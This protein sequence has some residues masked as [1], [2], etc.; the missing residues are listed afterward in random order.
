MIYPIEDYD[1]LSNLFYKPIPIPDPT[2]LRSSLTITG[3]I[4]DLS[5]S[6]Y[7]EN[8]KV[9]AYNYSVYDPE[10]D[11]AG[12]PKIEVIGSAICKKDGSYYMV[13]EEDELIGLGIPFE[14]ELFVFQGDRQLNLDKQEIVIRESETQ[15]TILRHLKVFTLA[16]VKGIVR[17]KNF[18]GA[19]GCLVEL[20]DGLSEEV[21]GYAVTDLKGKYEIPYGEPIIKGLKKRSKLRLRYFNNEDL[22]KI[23]ETEASITDSKS[24]TFEMPTSKT[25]I[26]TEQPYLGDIDIDEEYDCAYEVSSIENTGDSWTVTKKIFSINEDES[27]EENNYWK[28]LIGSDNN[29]F[30]VLNRKVVYSA[31]KKSKTTYIR[32]T[33]D[34]EIQNISTDVIVYK[35]VI[36]NYAISNSPIVYTGRR[37]ETINFQF[38]KDTL[39]IYTRLTTRE[40]ELLPL[41]KTIAIEEELIPIRSRKRSY[42]MEEHPYVASVTGA[43]LKNVQHLGNARDLNNTLR[44]EHEDIFFGLIMKGCKADISSLFSMSNYALTNK[45]RKA[46]SENIIPEQ[47]MLIVKIEQL[48]D[49]IVQ[50]IAG[51]F[52]D[53]FSNISDTTILA[54]SNDE[55]KRSEFTKCLVEY[56]YD[57]QNIDSGFWEKLN[58]SAEDELKLKLVVDY[59][60]LCESNNAFINLFVESGNLVPLNEL[61]KL[62]KDEIIAKISSASETVQSEILSTNYL[63]EDLLDVNAFSALINEKIE[64]YHPTRSLFL[65]LDKMSDL[66]SS[67]SLLNTKFNVLRKKLIS[68]TETSTTHFFDIG[69][70]NSKEFNIEKSLVR[71]YTENNL[72]LFESF[73]TD[74]TSYTKTDWIDFM[75]LIQRV[76]SVTKYSI[77]ETLVYLIEKGFNSAFDVVK[78]G[79]TNFIAKTSD[80]LES[81]NQAYI[82]NAAE[83]KVNKALSLLNK[84]SHATNSGNPTVVSPNNPIAQS[85]TQNV[86]LLTLPDLEVLFGD[87]DITDT[88]H[89]ES[90]L[91]PAAYLVDILNLL[92]QYKITDTTTLYDEIIERRPD[93]GNIPLNCENAI[94]P[95]PYIDLVIEIL[96]SEI[97]KNENLAATNPEELDKFNFNTTKSSDQLKVNPENCLYSVYDKIEES[98][99]S[100]WQ[101]TPFQLKSEELKIY[102]EALGINRSKLVEPFYK[103]T[104]DNANPY[105]DALGLTKQDLEFVYPETIPALPENFL[106]FINNDILDPDESAGFLQIR[107]MITDFLDKSVMNLEYF[108]LLL[109]S[110]YVNP[111]VNNDGQNVRHTIHFKTKMELKNAYL[112]FITRD[113]GNEFMK[114]MYQFKRLLEITKWPV[115]VLDAV[116]LSDSRFSAFYDGGTANTNPLLDKTCIEEIGKA[117]KTQLSLNVSS[118]QIAGLYGDLKFLEYKNEKSFAVEYFEENN[119]PEEHKDSLK[120]LC[121]EGV[122]F[123]YILG[124]PALNTDDTFSSFIEYLQGVMQFDFEEMN[125]LLFVSEKS[126]EQHIITLKG[127]LNIIR[128]WQLINSINVSVN[129][130]VSICKLLNIS[131]NDTISD[132]IPAITNAY[133]L[134]IS[135]NVDIDELLYLLTHERLEDSKLPTDEDLAIICTNINAKKTELQPTL[136]DVINPETFKAY[137]IQELAKISGASNEI[138]EYLVTIHILNSKTLV[139]VALDETLDTNTTVKYIK[140]L[141]I[142]RILDLSQSDFENMSSI[143]LDIFNLPTSIG[144]QSSFNDFEKLIAICDVGIFLKPEVNR[145]EFYNTVSTNDK[146]AVDLLLD[147]YIQWKAI[148]SVWEHNEMLDP[149]VA[150][151]Y[152]SNLTWFN[153]LGEVNAYFEKK[154]IDTSQAVNWLKWNNIQLDEIQYISECAEKKLGTEVYQ[155]K[156][157]EGR[158]ELRIKQRN[159]LVQYILETELAK[160][161]DDRL[162]KDINDLY[163]YFLIDTQMTPAVSSS[164]IL[165]A[166]LAVQL[167]IQRIQF[168]LEPGKSLSQEDEKKWDWMGIYRVWEANRKI[169]LYPENWIEPELRDNKSTFFKELEKELTSSEL[170]KEVIENSY[171]NYVSKLE[172]V[173]NI[174]FCQMY[175]EEIGSYSILHVIGRSRFEPREYFY[176]K[177]INESYWT[178]W[179]K[180]NI[181]IHSE[182]IA[183]VVINDRLIVFWL[184]FFDDAK[185]PSDSDLKADTSQTT[186]QAKK[187]SKQLKVQIS[188]SEFIDKKWTEKRSCEQQV[189]YNTDSK[190]KMNYRFVYENGKNDDPNYLHIIAPKSA[191]KTGDSFMVECFNHILLTKQS[192]YKGSDYNIPDSMQPFAQKVK[193]KAQEDWV[194]MPVV[195]S[196]GGAYSHDI[197]ENIGNV[198]T[199]LYPHQYKSFMC[200]SPFVVE[201]KKQSVVFI[202]TVKADKISPLLKKVTKVSKT[203]DKADFIKD[204]RISDSATKF[205]VDTYDVKESSKIENYREEANTKDRSFN[206][207]ET[208]EKESFFTD[209]DKDTLVVKE[210]LDDKPV[211]YEKE[212]FTYVIPENVKFKPVINA[213]LGYHPYMGTMRNVLQTHGITGVLDPIKPSSNDYN[214]LLPKQANKRY[215]TDF[216]LNTEVVINSAISADENIGYIAEQFEFQSKGASSIY[217]WE[218]FFHIPYIISNRYF[219]E[220]N[221]DE[222]LKWLH[223]I[224]D[225]RVSEG[226]EPAKYWKFKPF[227]DYHATEGI[228]DLLYDLSMNEDSDSDENELNDQIEIWSSD[229][230]KPHNIAQIRISAYMKAVI[231]KYIDTLIARGDNSFRVDTMESINEATQY[232]ILGAQLLGKKPEILETSII[233]AKTYNEFESDAMGNGIEYFEEALIKPE[234]SAYLEKFVE[235]N[236]MEIA[237]KP[238]SQDKDLKDMVT[239]IFSSIDKTDTVAKQYFGIPKNDKMFGY[240][241]LVADRLFKIRN[242]LNI[243][244]YKRTVALFA[245]PIDPGML[246]KAAAAG[247]NI[248]QLVN[249]GDASLTQYRFQTLLQRAL[250]I[251]GEVK[252]LGAGLLS[253]LEKRDNETISK[254]RAGHELKLTE[255]LSSIKEKNIEDAVLGI[256]QLQ[257]QKEIINFRKAHYK[258]LEKISKKEQQQM[259]YQDKALKTQMH[260]QLLQLQASGLSLIPNFNVGAAGFGGT[261]HFVMSIGGSQL[262][263]MGGMIASAKGMES[264]IKSHKASRAGTM[265][266]YDRRKEDWDFQADMAEKELGQLEIQVLSAQIRKE[267]SNLDMKNHLSQIE[268]SKE[269]LEILSSKFTNEDLYLW[270]IGE[271]NTV[272][273]SAF[274]MAYKMAKQAE[275][276]YSFEL[277]PENPKSIITND[278]FDANNKGLLAGEKLYLQL[279]QMELDYLT[280]HKR[281]YELTKHVS[282]ALLD[283]QK[284]LDLR[285]G[286]TCEITLP[287]ILFNMDHPGHCNRRIK[288]VSLTIPC[289]SGAYTTISANLSLISSQIKVSATKTISIDSK[290]GTM[291]TSSSLNDSGMFELNF[292]DARYLPFEGAGVD[293]N[294]SLTLPN[295]VRQ[296]D[297]NSISDVILHINYTAQDGLSREVVETEVFNTLNSLASDS[298]MVSMFSLKSQYPE[299]WAE[300]G[301]KD[302]VIEIKKSQLPYYLQ[303]REIDV[304]GLIAY[305]VVGNT[306]IP[307]EILDVTTND[308]VSQTVTINMEDVTDKPKDIVL[309]MK[310]ITKDTWVAE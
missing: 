83:Y 171:L 306:N 286:G 25:E 296:F 108:K 11:Q 102:C 144:N 199:V 121:N 17:R 298:E 289:V 310:Y 9:C 43:S 10:S 163:S 278:H 183:P 135:H 184:E 237:A 261:P 14:L 231:M 12:E 177:L 15:T 207:E 172:K 60:E 201:S 80:V 160:A 77:F 245:P 260:S 229:P 23:S 86:Q 185:E 273:R 39:D 26:I 18:I 115:S 239:S 225:P 61:L 299:A 294:W 253:A 233:N 142:S 24:T 16:S 63:S 107:L 295:K 34:S 250:E 247:I 48:K 128:S 252:S 125:E 155:G 3:K 40:I 31:D 267:I 159:A 215:L 95:I 37:K 218:L 254:L 73:F 182:H 123:N 303:G 56:S 152:N 168:N 64:L 72:S 47:A 96:E 154:D 192:I 263:T 164:R 211:F 50:F 256:E 220:G 111:F 33:E 197:V 198:T 65:R 234:N 235:S 145:F 90:V 127:V 191:G 66:N 224:F 13:I 53:F 2:P 206:D 214:K 272:Y 228:D 244:G 221:Y 85:D 274:D 150:T 30:K 52:D 6:G 161:E 280:D 241:D 205:K 44:L 126:D 288:S 176:R 141:W 193:M 76:F 82:Y 255:M 114:R 308:F 230:F 173:A 75:N 307:R 189:I 285:Q 180:M 200:N 301:N 248:S 132:F 188:W 210:T 246:V 269:S 45:I 58:L 227:S 166:T 20:Y 178:P 49:K 216:E 143:P 271:I 151:N 67:N 190:Q 139:E 305:D 290:V 186:V 195:S 124:T 21:L 99:I 208:D 167:F 32:V 194:S 275:K 304:T 79:R 130:F 223:Y 243:D 284:I 113:L 279:K 276:A 257:K 35:E 262:S 264:S 179:E 103:N 283:P 97:F 112:E 238:S 270:M 175:N 19:V 162:I 281:T 74:L 46:V 8:L 165:Q 133:K 87:Q 70:N 249:G 42:S 170:T 116:I 59:S 1:M 157:S 7:G 174:E 101:Q 226:E 204:Y 287:E 110:Y 240:W 54:I 81:T 158:D 282:L 78:V 92:K 259:D 4:Y 119:L 51:R 29:P 84:Y 22:I 293:S 94:T 57:S 100:S 300:I 297:Y 27:A 251:C 109:S 117:K 122:D 71:D 196:T 5:T 134:M 105:F 236:E 309:V 41:S 104:T 148:L 28:V 137:I 106:P 302:V 93:I 138:T 36:E 120:L 219:L 242:S 140:A 118:R 91:G 292:N 146:V 147:D 213:Y 129:E 265:A 156:V 202:P 55:T 136:E 258:G 203:I 209:D 212:N 149:D 187:T 268:Q 62:T 222:A 153:T 181:E 38:I 169:F 98:P 68:E 88:K 217:N 266:G 69:I 89:G 131:G 291:A 232:Y 277:C